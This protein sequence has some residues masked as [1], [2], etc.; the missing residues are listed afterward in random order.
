MNLDGELHAVITI[1]TIEVTRHKAE[2]VLSLANQ[3]PDAA[4]ALVA[5]AIII[6]AAALEQATRSVLSDEAKRIAMEEEINYSETL[7]G[8]LY[9]KSLWL[10]I[11]S[12]PLVLTHG[13]FRLI[14]EN[15]IAEQLRELVTLRNR[16]V[17]INEEAIHLIG[18]NEQVR[19]E[20]DH[21]IVKVPVPVN[22]WGEVTLAKA[23]GF[24]NAVNTYFQEVL[25]PESGQIA[26]GTIIA[27]IEP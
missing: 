25:L 6:L 11:E 16:L 24:R 17:H 15:P 7:P 3:H 19:I 13:Q 8:K 23:E 27:Q 26:S 20:D 10:R 4:P 12:I 22:P 5:S 18:P 9:K 14:S 2:E 21:V 1:S